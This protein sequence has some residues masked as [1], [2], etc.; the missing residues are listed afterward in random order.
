MC[1]FK[2][3][4]FLLILVLKLS[5]LNITQYFFKST[6]FLNSNPQKQISGLFVPNLY[7]SVIFSTPIIQF[8]IKI[9]LKGN[10][11]TMQEE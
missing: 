10:K 4:I 2:N 6:Q 5:I 11:I 3:F 9:Y 1:N 7:F 8:Y